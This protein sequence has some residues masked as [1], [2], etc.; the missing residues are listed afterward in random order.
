MCILNIVSSQK[1][2]Y[3]VDVRDIIT[4]SQWEYICTGS[5]HSVR[6]QNLLPNGCD[7]KNK[8]QIYFHIYHY[9]LWN[10][11]ALVRREQKTHF[12]SSV[13]EPLD[14][15][16]KFWNNKTGVKSK[17]RRRVM[18]FKNRK[19]EWSSIILKRWCANWIRSL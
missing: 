11:F 10:S 8:I 2:F 7:N 9:L 12:I 4:V 17:N 6:N 1:N 14:W 15:S 3:L 19:V 18:K 13:I 16:R 5:E